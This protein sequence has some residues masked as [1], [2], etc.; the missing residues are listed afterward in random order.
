MNFVSVSRTQEE[1][2]KPRFPRT[3]SPI[4]AACAGAPIAMHTSGS[5]AD[6]PKKLFCHMSRNQGLSS[7]EFRGAVAQE[8]HSYMAAGL[9]FVPIFISE[10]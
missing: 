1:N 4:S 3:K 6:S 10:Q 2:Q 9:Y 5:S 7:E 8:K